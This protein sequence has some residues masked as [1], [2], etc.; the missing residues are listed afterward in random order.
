MSNGISNLES[1]ITI[2]HIIPLIVTE[3][4][5]NVPITSQAH[6]HRDLHRRLAKNVNN[7]SS[8]TDCDILFKVYLLTGSCIPSVGRVG[9][10]SSSVS[11]SEREWVCSPL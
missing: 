9:G 1:L 6:T 3:A 4:T 7:L 10:K 8:E 11:E 2:L 5:P